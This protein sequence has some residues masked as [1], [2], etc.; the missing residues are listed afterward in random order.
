ME[1]DEARSKELERRKQVG[2]LIAGWLAPCVLLAFSAAAAFDAVACSCLRQVAVLQRQ[3]SAD[4][5]PVG[6]FPEE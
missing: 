1:E 5:E 4:E 3:S 2:L 6:G